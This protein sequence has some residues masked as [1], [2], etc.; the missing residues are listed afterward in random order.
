MDDEERRYD[1]IIL[2]SGNILF[3]DDGF[4][5]AVVDH[6]L[7]NFDLPGTALALDVGTGIQ[8]ILFDILLSENP[9]RKIL[10]VDVLDQQ[11]PPGKLFWLKP[12]ALQKRGNGIF[13]LH[14]PPAPEMLKELEKKGIEVWVLCC[15]PG[16][17]SQ[18]MRI[19]LSPIMAQAVLKACDKIYKILNRTSDDSD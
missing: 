12:D 9:P 2:G 6:L 13:S 14:L 16:E 17:I 5:P 3:G 15:Q 10:V 7:R 1:T 11:A 18:T 8:E 19:G 4:G